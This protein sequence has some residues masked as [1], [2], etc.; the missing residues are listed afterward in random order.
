MK[1]LFFHLKIC[2]ISRS[3]PNK[4]SL[5]PVSFL[6][7]NS[8]LKILFQVFFFFTDFISVDIAL[9]SPCVLSAL[10]GPGGLIWHLITTL[11]FILL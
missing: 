6:I 2:L 11:L 9:E 8:S 7:K 3:K 10:I 5:I 4:I 1:R